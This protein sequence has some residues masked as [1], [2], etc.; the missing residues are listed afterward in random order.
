MAAMG[1]ALDFLR[2]NALATKSKIKLKLLSDTEMKSKQPTQTACFQASLV[3]L[4]YQKTQRLLEFL[5]NK[6]NLS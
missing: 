6:I 4:E 5:E 1:Q 3:N 2:R